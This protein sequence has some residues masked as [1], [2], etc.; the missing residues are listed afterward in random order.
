MVSDKIHARAKGVRTLLT[1]QPTEGRSRE[2]GLR[3]GEM[4]RDC[5]I[6]YGASA[7]IKERLLISSDA[8]DV[9]VCRE[10]G[11]IGNECICEMQLHKIKRNQNDVYFKNISDTFYEKCTIKLDSIMKKKRVEVNRKAVITIP[12]AFKLLIQE[13][14]SMSICVKISVNEE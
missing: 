10:C 14:L 9:Q 3:L 13:L 2:G 5:L 11:I 6:S 7:L 4:E 1:R 8:V 12:Y